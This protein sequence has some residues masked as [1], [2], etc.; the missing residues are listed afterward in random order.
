MVHIYEKIK[1]NTAVCLSTSYAANKNMSD[2]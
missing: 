1:R 2:I